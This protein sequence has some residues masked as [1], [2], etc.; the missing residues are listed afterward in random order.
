M[1][2]R[3]IF[4]AN[5]LL[6]YCKSDSAETTNIDVA[7]KVSKLLKNE[8]FVFIP[9]IAL[10]EV[11]YNLKKKDIF[12]L[13][14]ETIPL[15]FNFLQLENLIIHKPDTKEL[16]F[17][18]KFVENFNLTFYDATYL[19]LSIITGYPLVTMDKPFYKRIIKDYPDTILVG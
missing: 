7:E 6:N 5:V 11:L 19:Y 17:I 8:I 12:D 13:S 16:K 14:K 1:Q 9:E 15:F 18:T 10:H 2:N 4:D 3:F